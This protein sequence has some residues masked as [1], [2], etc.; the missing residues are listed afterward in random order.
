MVK[1]R[2]NDVPGGALFE[3]WKLFD[4]AEELIVQ[5]HVDMFFFLCLRKIIVF[6][7]SLFLFVVT[8]LAFQVLLQTI[9]LAPRGIAALGVELFTGEHKH[10]SRI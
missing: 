7:L 5:A 9:F 4:D 3:G 1:L 8:C 6:I 2:S 10:K